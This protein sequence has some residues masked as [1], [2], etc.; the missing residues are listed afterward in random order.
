MKSKRRIVG[1]FVK[2]PLGDVSHSYARVLPE[3]SFAF[4]DSRTTQDIPIEQVIAHSVLFFAAVMDQAV[5]RGRWPVAGHA[6]LDD[7]L[8]APP[9]FIQDPLNR[10]SFEI[11][12]GGKTR[13]ATRE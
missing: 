2:I 6:P 9:R 11:Y 8:K 10:N 3:A 4:Y 12:E 13:P 1:D 5:K 7:R